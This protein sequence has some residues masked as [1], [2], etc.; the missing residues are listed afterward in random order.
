MRTL[1]RK[2]TSNGGIGAS[3]AVRFI[4]LKLT[5]RR[6]DG[7]TR[8][9][10]PERSKYCTSWQAGRPRFTSTWLYS[11]VSARLTISV[12]MSLPMISYDQPGGRLSCSVMARLYASCPLELAA[13]HSRTLRVL[14]RDLISSRS[15]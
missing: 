9:C 3:G 6:S 8:Q 14:D 10:A 12:E 1:R 13:D 7:A 11:A 5:F 4:S 2:I 15:T